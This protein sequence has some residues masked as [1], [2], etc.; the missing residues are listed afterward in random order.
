MRHR[1]A[2][3]HLNRST[4]ERNR[5]IRQLVTTFLKHDRLETT[6]AKAKA[7]QGTIERLVKL[8]GNNTPLTHTFLQEYLS[9]KNLRKRLQDKITPLAKNTGGYT[10]LIKTKNRP[11]DNAQ[12]SML[13]WSIEQ[14]KLS[15]K[16]KL[17]TR[18]S[19]RQETKK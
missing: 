15:E 6:K 10:R 9:N 8:V 7:V 12:M 13:M 4:N 14:A 5:L 11:G 18:G 1:I 17:P 16:E 19:K 2:G 3:Y